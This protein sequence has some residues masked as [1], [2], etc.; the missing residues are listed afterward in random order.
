M[1]AANTN[2][3]D[4]KGLAKGH[5]FTILGVHEYAG[6][7]LVQ[8]RNPWGKE[9]YTGPWSDSDMTKWNVNAQQQMSHVPNAEDGAFWMPIEEFQKLFKRWHVSMYQEWYRQ[10]LMVEW[11][12]A[13]DEKTLAWEITNKRDQQVVVG[14]QG[15]SDKMFMDKTCKSSLKQESIHFELV[16]AAGKPVKDTS[17]SVTQHYNGEA[18]FIYDK[19][20][21]GIYHLKVRQMGA[22]KNTGITKFGVL[23]YGESSYV[24]IVEQKIH[25]K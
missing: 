7:F 4:T 16:D 3:G 12:R 10:N 21:T 24:D 23:S 20:P 11:D 9:T 17:G 18:F 14:V 2:T 19:L 15:P 25:K 22:K 13:T 5:A 8:V 1:T 6:Q